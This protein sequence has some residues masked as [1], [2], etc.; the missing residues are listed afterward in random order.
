MISGPK[1]VGRTVQMQ[2][3]ADDISPVATAPQQQAGASNLHKRARA[4]TTDDDG[5]PV[6][7]TRSAHAVGDGPSTGLRLLAGAGPSAVSHG[8][9]TGMHGASACNVLPGLH[10]ATLPAASAHVYGMTAVGVGPQAQSEADGSDSV[11]DVFH[12]ADDR[13]LPVSTYNQMV[14]DAWSATPRGL[15]YCHSCV[16]FMHV[17]MTV[18]NAVVRVLG[19]LLYFVQG[20]GVA[21]IAKSVLWSCTCCH[22]D[23]LV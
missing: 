19:V 12:G 6:Q 16:L 23:R 11:T 20:C 14:G 10:L 18:C 4:S 15:Q 3:T 22:A 5:P 13:V 9:V 17:P 1:R 7:R 21:R 8:G 2:S